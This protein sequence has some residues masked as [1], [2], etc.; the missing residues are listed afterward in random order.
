MGIRGIA[1][2]AA[3]G[4]EPVIGSTKVSSGDNNGS[5]GDAPPEILHAPDLEARAADLTPLE[6]DRAQPRRRLT[7]AAPLQ[8]PKP[9]RPAH[10]IPG[11][12]RRVVGRP[13]RPPLGLHGHGGGWPVVVWMNQRRYRTEYRS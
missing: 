3:V 10:L 8:I 13:R 7:V 6:Q 9:T 2:A 1:M 4:V 11:I 5:S 12:R